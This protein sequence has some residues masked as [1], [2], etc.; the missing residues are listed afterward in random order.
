MI[1]KVD[2]HV[3]VKTCTYLFA[4]PLILFM[5]LHAQF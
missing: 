5:T 3:G 4:L 1:D 2:L